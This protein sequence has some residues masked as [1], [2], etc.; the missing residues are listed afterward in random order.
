MRH[1]KLYLVEDETEQC[2]SKCWSK[3]CAAV[4][5]ALAVYKLVGSQGRHSGLGDRQLGSQRPSAYTTGLPTPRR[6]DRTSQ[7]HLF[8]LLGRFLREERGLHHPYG[9]S[10]RLAS[11]M[12]RSLD[13]LSGLQG[14]QLSCLSPASRQRRSHLTSRWCKRCRMATNGTS[15]AHKPCH[16]HIYHLWAYRLS[17][18]KSCWSLHRVSRE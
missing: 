2:H 7:R 11:R 6:H 14:D 1:H 18:W 8:I 3:L 9:L 10:E 17:L 12:R 13:L 15:P 5:D 16:T 4:M